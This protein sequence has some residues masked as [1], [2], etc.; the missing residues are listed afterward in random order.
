MACPLNSRCC[1]HNRVNR[2]FNFFPRLKVDITRYSRDQ[3][4]Q[5]FE[6]S[7]CAGQIVSNVTGVQK[8]CRLR[9]PS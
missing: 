3:A 6:D 5:G 1:E 4:T 9:R 8:L 2:E 7:E